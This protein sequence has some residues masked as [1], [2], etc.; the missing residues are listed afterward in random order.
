M[1]AIGGKRYNIKLETK[2][3]PLQKPILSKA[4]QQEEY[5]IKSKTRIAKDKW[6]EL[7]LQ[8]HCNKLEWV[9]IM[10]GI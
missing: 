4:Q 6:N 10:I 5:Y 7:K 9:D 1:T 2:L 3:P 8:I